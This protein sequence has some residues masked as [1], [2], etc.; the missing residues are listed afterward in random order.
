MDELF[1]VQL[2]DLIGLESLRGL[3][4]VI[5]SDLPTFYSGWPDLTLIR[6]GSV[7]LLEVKTTDKLQESQLITVP[8]IAKNIKVKILNV[9]RW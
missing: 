7:E 3:A 8:A 9:K 1:A 5:F 4:S 2:F 6:D